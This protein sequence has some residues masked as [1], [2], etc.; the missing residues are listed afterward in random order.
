MSRKLLFLGTVLLASCAGSPPSTLGLNGGNLY[1]C[2][3]KPNCV[4]SQASDSDHQVQ[5]WPYQ[6]HPAD[7]KQKLIGLIQGTD[8]ATL[9]SQQDNY[10]HA[11]YKTKLMGFVDDVEF[12]ITPAK[13]HM[14]SASRVGY[15]DLGA[16]KKR[17]ETL[18]EQFL[19]CCSEAPE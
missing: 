12:L 15:S 10:I 11:E 2:P 14:R 9:V 4:S 19:P 1:P 13:V 5:A 16:N 18:A 3:D 7:A 6:G 8:N 17:V